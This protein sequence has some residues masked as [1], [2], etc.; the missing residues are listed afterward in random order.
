MLE[1]DKVGTIVIHAFKSKVDKAYL[2]VAEFNGKTADAHGSDHRTELGGR[3]ELGC[4][5]MAL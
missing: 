3:N 1:K 4:R 5:S 2:F